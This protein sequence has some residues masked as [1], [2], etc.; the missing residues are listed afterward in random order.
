MGEEIK[1]SFRWTPEE[2][3]TGNYWFMRA[4]YPPMLRFGFKF[5]CVLLIACGFGFYATSG[6]TFP[7]FIMPFIGIYLL[8]LRKYELRRRI[9]RKFKTK[10]EIEETVNLTL[11]DDSYKA[12]INEGSAV[13]KWHRIRTVRK[14]KGGYLVYIGE[15][16]T[17]MPFH[18]FSTPEDQERAEELFKAKVP[19]F[20]IIR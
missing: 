13:I 19:D 20:K 10:V 4:K 6:W 12:E 11:S 5:A 18:A 1:A 16:S 3:T 14:G 9:R 17:W 7:T 8:F 15:V 2:S